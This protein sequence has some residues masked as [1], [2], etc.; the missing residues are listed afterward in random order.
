MSKS[1][2]S[3]VVPVYNIEQYVKKC[4][5]SVVEQDYEN[6]E[7]ILIDDGSRDN[8]GTICDQ[9]EKMDNR[10]KVVHKKNGGLS[11]AR[12]TGVAVATGSYIT[13][14]DGDDYIDT[15]YV[16][17]LWNAIKTY[18]TTMACSPLIFEYPNGNNKESLRFE[19][20]VVSTAEMIDIVFRA[21]YSIGVSACSKLMRIEDVRKHPFPVGRFHEDMTTIEDIISE[22]REIVIIPHATYHYVQRSTSITYANVNFDSL[23]YGLD[24]LEAKANESQS[25]MCRNAYI[26]RMFGL[27]NSYCRVVDVRRN[28]DKLKEVQ[29]KLKRNVGFYIKDSET[30]ITDK[31]KG[32]LLSTSIGS[33]SLIQDMERKHTQKVGQRRV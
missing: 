24:Y 2:V 29:K 11:D 3:V 6:I 19:E 22:N 14:I 15:D 10:I 4:V 31:I 8:S 18:N 17:S 1:K 25:E 21:K 23:N 20:Q 33:F 30:T 27:M 7:I 9:F 5:K 16:S 28:E 13:F 32:L 26:H 12:N